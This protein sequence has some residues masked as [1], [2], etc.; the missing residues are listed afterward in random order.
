[1]EMP[2]PGQSFARGR[3]G[4]DVVSL[5][6]TGD[7]ELAFTRSDGFE[8]PPVAAPIPDLSPSVTATNT[9]GVSYGMTFGA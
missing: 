3:P 5:V 6:I 8:I 9:F 1:L 7:D 4:H 2:R